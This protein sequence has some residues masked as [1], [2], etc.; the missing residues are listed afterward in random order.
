MKTK[1]LFLFLSALF[2]FTSCDNTP[3]VLPEPEPELKTTNQ[4]LSFSFEKS[5]NEAYIDEDVVATIADGRIDLSLSEKVN[6][7]DLIA[8]FTHNGESISIG[9][10]P[11][12]S[13]VT[14]NDFSKQ[15]VYTVRAED[16]SIKK[17]NVNIGKLAEEVA[18]IPHLYIVTENQ[19][20]I[21]EKKVYRKGTIR[22]VGGDE[23]DDFEGDM[24]IRGRGNSTWGMPKKPYRFKLDEAASLLGLSAEK[25]WVLLQNYID[26]S[27]MCNSVAMKTGQLLEMPFTHHMIPVDV[28]LNGEYIGSYTFTEHKEVEDN[29]INVGEGGWLLELDTNFDEDFKF[30]SNQFKLPVMIQYPELGDMAGAEAENIYNEMRSDFNALEELIFAESFPNNNYLDYFDAHAFVDFL[31]VHTLTDNEEI[32]HPKSTYIYKKKGGKYNMGP[33]WDF[34]WAFGYEGTYTHFVDPNRKMFWTGEKRGVGTFF[35]SKLTQDPAIQEIY[36]TEWE[37]FKTQKYPILVEY[38][39]EYAEKIRE[40]HA[41]DQVRWKQSSGPID[42]YLAKLLNWLDQRVVY[43]DSLYRGE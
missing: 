23:Y 12:V 41:K 32:N 27:L 1:F 10:T 40:S 25:D 8:T 29:R 30:I 21:D 35:F 15:V 42:V 19:Q 22:I 36:R 4:L 13:G 18:Q 20:P 7:T 43:M 17:Y 11:Q 39:E 31:I 26:P 24:K 34:D 38:I 14:A 16:K 9:S 2:L 6:V 5:K 33:I 28:T 37:K 3:D